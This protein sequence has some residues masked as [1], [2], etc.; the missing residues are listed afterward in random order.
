[1]ASTRKS[2]RSANISWNRH[3]LFYRVETMPSPTASL[4]LP[5]HLQLVQPAE[6]IEM[7][8]DALAEIVEGWASECMERE[9]RMLLMICVLRGG[10][11]FFSDLVQRIGYSIEPAFCR[12]WSYAKTVTARP[13]DS[14]RIDWPEVNVTGRDVVLVDNICDTGRTF[15]RAVA[16]LRQHDPA[17]IRT[18]SFIRR[19][20]QRLIHEPT[21]SGLSYLGD[22]WL[23][24]YGL[25]DRGTTMMNARIVA[26]VV[27]EHDAGLRVRN[28]NAPFAGLTVF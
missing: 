7:V 13:E 21:L 22:E 28:S 24:G 9:G 2:H 6:D 15:A 4:S 8:L 20:R 26:R 23:V 18:V 14:V 25:R 17:S 27:Q 3:G 1:M 16:D 5:Q 12:A 11:F 19:K 10:V